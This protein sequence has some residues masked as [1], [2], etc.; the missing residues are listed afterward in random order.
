MLERAQPYIDNP[1]LVRDILA[2]GCDKARVTAQSTM[3][4][5]RDAMGLKI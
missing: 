2:D 3:R 4:A 1:A 5:V